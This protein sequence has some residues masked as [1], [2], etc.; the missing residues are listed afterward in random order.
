MHT[1][2]NTNDFTTARELLKSVES[3]KEYYFA[4]GKYAAIIRKNENCFEYLELQSEI[5]KGL[6]DMKNDYDEVNWSDYC[7]K[8]NDSD[9]VW[10]VDTGWL[11]VGLMLITFDKKKF[12]NLFADYPHNM[13]PEEVEIFDKE[14]P[15][16]A[17]FFS[18]RKK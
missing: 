4:V 16:W 14:N 17:D 15:F 12:Y 18:N 8:E 10:W 6:E 11:E 5:S 13:T 9:K 7:Y 2:K 3:E 1:A